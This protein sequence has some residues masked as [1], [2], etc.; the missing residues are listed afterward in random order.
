MFYHYLKIYK[1]ITNL[2]I[3]LLSINKYYKLYFSYQT[4]LLVEL[5]V[6]I[7]FHLHL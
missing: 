4:Q 6:N 2:F 3:F 7:L 1:S 5:K